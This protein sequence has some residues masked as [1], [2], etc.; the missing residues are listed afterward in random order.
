MWHASLSK[1]RQYFCIN[2]TTQR[3]LNLGAFVSSFHLLTTPRDT[4]QR[5]DHHVRRKK[6]WCTAWVSL[7]SS[8]SCHR[9]STY[10][11]DQN[12]RLIP[13]CMKPLQP[14]RVRDR[15]N[16]DDNQQAV[17]DGRRGQAA[18]QAPAVISQ[19]GSVK[20]GSLGVKSDFHRKIWFELSRRVREKLVCNRP[21]LPGKGAKFFWFL[22]EVS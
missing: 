12:S 1:Y 14:E 19:S 2:Q 10:F 13:V 7:K 16:L 9:E 20:K 4:F 11:H 3:L 8:P 22:A 6:A 18:Q 5:T 21:D 17:L 15:M